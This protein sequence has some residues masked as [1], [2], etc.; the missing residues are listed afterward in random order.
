[1]T[2]VENRE[3]NV[4][5][6]IH[7][8]RMRRGL[9]L[10]ALAGRCGISAN[11][12]SL[13]ERGLNSPTVSSLHQLALALDVPITDLFQEEGEQPAVY[14][15]C[16]C[17]SRYRSGG[18]ELENLGS[19]LPHQQIEPFC[20]TIEPGCGTLDDPIYHPGQEFVYCIEGQVEYC[21]GECCYPL[22]KGDSLLL[23]ATCPHGL[24]NL[25]PSRAVLLL[26]FQSAQGQHLARQRH[27]DADYS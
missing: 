15:K 9:S 8:L 19:G 5:R 21:V 23:E 25:M 1:M 10:R 16:G 4:G 12:I 2:L 7:A 22:K 17:G 24:R 27:L 13:I 20:L 26:V 3:P 6:Q 11:G 18:V 14:V